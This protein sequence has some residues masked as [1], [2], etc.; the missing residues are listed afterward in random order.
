M[1]RPDPENEAP[2]SVAEELDLLARVSRLLLAL[3]GRKGVPAA[4]YD[5]ELIAL[6]DEIAISRA[7]DVPPLVEHMT[8][9]QALAAQPAPHFVVQAAVAHG[10]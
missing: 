6:R 5:A 3:R 2:A 9:L 4:D 7:E 10:Q 1:H 8:R